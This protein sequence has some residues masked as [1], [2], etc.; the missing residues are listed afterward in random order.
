[1]R[2]RKISRF[3]AELAETNPKFKL[4]KGALAEGGLELMKIKSEAKP[5][6]QEYKLPERFSYS[7]LVAFGKCPYQYKLQFI[8][9]VPVFGKAQFSYGKSMHETLEEF[10]KRIFEKLENKQVDLFGGADIKRE[11]EKIGKLISFEELKK[12][13]EV[14]WK[15][16]WYSSKEEKEK[17]LKRAGES[18][19]V[20]YEKIKDEP[21]QTEA[22][23]KI[24]YLKIKDYSIKGVIDRIDRLTD[25]SVVLIDYKTGE[26]KE[27]K[28][29]SAENKMQL[30]IYQIAAEEVLKERVN[31][32][33]FYY[34]D[35]NSTL[36]FLG[37][38]KDKD[39]VKQEIIK[40]AEA[41]RTSDFAA[42][43]SQHTCAWCDF[44]NICEFR[45]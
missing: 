11:K 34:I 38:E 3:L 8:L 16:E 23:E 41:I 44:R 32:L 22:V 15:D 31:K 18:L 35:N 12:I 36:E 45:V 33:V 1:M 40:R 37:E 20:F 6:K 39:K 13:F 10:F 7:Q 21:C 5:I 43:P 4:A 17:Y 2:K 24:F 29:V 28:T 26:A 25:G 14:K 30:L 42:T 27:E 9:H 19:K